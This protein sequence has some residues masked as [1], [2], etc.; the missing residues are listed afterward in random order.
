MP[1]RPL[2]RDGHFTPEDIAVL[3]LVFDEVLKDLRLVDRTDPVVNMVAKQIID[4][5]RHGE[6]DPKVLKDAAI[7]SFS[8]RR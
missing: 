3:T 8:E 7:R 5:A 6:R 2:L 4:L 1:I